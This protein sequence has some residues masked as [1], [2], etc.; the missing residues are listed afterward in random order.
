MNWINYARGLLDEIAG[1]DGDKPRKAAAL[2]ELKKVVAELRAYDVSHLAADVEAFR[3][4]VLA[5]VE[6]FLA[7]KAPA[8]PVAK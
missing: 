2:A 4:E 6:A 3:V 1:N 7:P 5:E 8:K